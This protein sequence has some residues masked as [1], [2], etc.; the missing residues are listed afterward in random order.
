MAI[1]AD[2][3]SAQNNKDDTVLA[4]AARF[5]TGLVSINATVEDMGS[6]T[7]NEPLQQNIEIE[8]MSGDILKAFK[9]NP[10]AQNLNAF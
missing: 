6:Y 10:Y 7:Y 2:G 1:G 5:N 4:A 8:R 3:Y 9:E